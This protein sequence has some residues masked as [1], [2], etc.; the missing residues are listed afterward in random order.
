MRWGVS[1]EEVQEGGGICIPIA[2]PF[3]VWWTPIQYYKAIILQL[4]Q[5]YFKKERIWM[6]G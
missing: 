2:D 6:D 5:I 4:K 3:D 1:W